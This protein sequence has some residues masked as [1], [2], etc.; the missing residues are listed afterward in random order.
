MFSH[1]SAPI[2]VLGLVGA[3]GLN[4]KPCG[5]AASACRRRHLFV[6]PSSALAVTPSMRLCRRPRCIRSPPSCVVHP[7]PSLA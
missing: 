1:P 4:G 2:P 7:Q 3:A 5:Y 6:A